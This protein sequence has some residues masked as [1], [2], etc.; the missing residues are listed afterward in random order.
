MRKLFLILLLL[1]SF[2][3]KAGA[4][5][6]S[7]DA[8][9]SMALIMNVD[10]NPIDDVSTNSNT[11]ALKGDGE[12]DYSASGKFGGCFNFD[13]T[14]DYVQVSDNANLKVIPGTMIFYVNFDSV[15]GGGREDWI[16]GK[17]D[18]LTRD[19][20]F[21]MVSAG[22][23]ITGGVGTATTTETA[24]VTSTTSVSAAGGWYHIAYVFAA[25]GNTSYLYLNG[26]EE[27]TGSA[28]GAWSFDTSALRLG[29]SLQTWW[30]ELDGQLDE[31][32]WFQDVLTPT[33]INDIMDN[34]LVGSG[35]AAAVSM[36]M[37]AFGNGIANGIGRGMR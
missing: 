29:D 21:C 6:Y 8:N 2:V 19:G 1:S 7:Q 36:P 10:E 11:G 23:K 9:C 35:A 30:D 5:D 12:P 14:D 18:G 27:D 22:D 13:G 26:I 3:G 20:A 32:A 34:G 33:E 31:V 25:S 24:V 4:T 37:S 16:V 17:A 15:P 28:A